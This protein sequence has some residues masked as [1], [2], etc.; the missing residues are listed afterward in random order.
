MRQLRDYQATA[1]DRLREEVRKGYRR[2]MLQMPTGSGKTLVATEIANAATAK[3]RR[4]IF[5]VPLI[6]LIDQ[7]VKSLY[8]HGV[9][10]V[11]VIQ[12][13]DARHFPDRP[14]Q[15]CSSQTLQRR[16][17]PKAHLVIR[18]EA[19]KVYDF[20]IKWMMSEKWADVPFIGLSATPWTRGLGT[21]Y[22]RLIVGET[23]AGLI[24][25]GLL[26]KF[27]VFA[28][29]APD[30]SD[31]RS[32]AGD[33]HQGELSKTMR[34]AKLTGDI[35]DT[36]HRM[37]AGRPTILFAVDRQHAKDLS[38]RFEAGNVSTAFLDCN[39]PLAEREEVRKDFKRGKIKIVCNVDVIGTGVD[40]PEISCIIYARPTKSEMRFVQNIG[41]GLR[42][43]PGKDDLLILDHSTTSLK[44]GYVTDIHHEQ[45]HVGKTPI[46]AP[47]A[48]R[49]P[50]HCPKCNFVKPYGVPK[51]ANCGFVPEKPAPLREAN[52]SLGEFKG[53]PK[54]KKDY[55]I[56][57]KKQF[58]AELMLHCQT[59]GYKP[60]WAANKY[61][62]RFEVWPSP[63]VQATPIAKTISIST[64]AWLKKEAIAYRIMQRR[65]YQPF[66]PRTAFAED[67]D[68]QNAVRKAEPDDRFVAG[69][70]MTNEDF[71]L[72]K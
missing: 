26:S 46:H 72:F 21:Y 11:G 4:V 43:A 20:D 23:I 64:S 67:K 32:I 56:E 28:P 47:G 50:K 65:G 18:D 71:D 41:R 40:W 44:L 5:E 57:D 42:P 3:D 9:R 36:W 52:G 27:R 30:L 10:E 35:V 61:R 31:V 63:E 66:A 48:P 53:K 7:T 2:I 39:S 33:Y 51:C 8:D 22:Q 29:S 58:F 34:N 17:L 13:N 25:R 59:R 54:K 69:T 49:L 45:M 68:L 14:V 15:V 37:G 24:E 62:K 19:H 55:T 1:L 6:S 70:L 16:E 38:D 60:G 12:G